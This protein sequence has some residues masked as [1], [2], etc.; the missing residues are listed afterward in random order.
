M[1]GRRCTRVTEI[2]RE[3]ATLREIGATIDYV[4]VVVHVL[5]DTACQ[6]GPEAMRLL[7][8]QPLLDRPGTHLGP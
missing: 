1:A 8:E 5:R 7:V 4:C 2:R 6:L 3:G